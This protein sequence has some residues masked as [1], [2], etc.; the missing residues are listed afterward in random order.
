MYRLTR[1]LQLFAR[2]TVIGSLL[3]LPP[4]HTLANNPC[5]IR[6][7]ITANPA[8]SF[9]V[10]GRDVQGDGAVIITPKD[11]SEPFGKPDSTIFITTR[12]QSR[13]QVSSPAYCTFEQTH[14]YPYQA[15]GLIHSDAPFLAEFEHSRK[16]DEKNRHRQPDSEDSFL[17]LQPSFGKS[18]TFKMGGD[19]FAPDDDNQQH[20]RRPYGYFHEVSGDIDLTIM[21]DFQLSQ[22]LGEYLP[23][24]TPWPSLLNLLG[25]GNNLSHTFWLFAENQPEAIT[26][27]QVT[28]EELEDLADNLSGEL[29]LN[30]LLPK[31]HPDH[32]EKLIQQLLILQDAFSASSAALSE[33]VLE[34]IRERLIEILS[35]THATI[36]LEFEH[37]RL[38]RDLEEMTGEV[39]ANLV[40]AHRPDAGTVYDEDDINKLILQTPVGKQG[41]NKGK[42]ARASGKTS[43][44]ANGGSSVDKHQQNADNRDNEEVKSKPAAA[45]TTGGSPSLRI[46]FAG[47]QNVGKSSLAKAMVGWDCGF[48]VT[49]SVN[50]DL[51][52]TYRYER[53]EVKTLPGYG[54]PMGLMQDENITDFL[55]EHRVQSNDVIVLTTSNLGLNLYDM[56]A[57]RYFLSHDYRV[58]IVR[59][60]WNLE[61]ETRA[62]KR[63][64]ELDEDAKQEL[65]QEVEREYIGYIKQLPEW[66]ESTEIPPIVFT[67]APDSHLN[68]NIAELISAIEAIIHEKTSWRTFANSRV[69]FEDFKFKIDT[70]ISSLIEEGINTSE[71]FELSFAKIIKM[72]KEE[73][74]VSLPEYINDEFVNEAISEIYE[75]D[76]HKNLKK[77]LKHFNDIRAYHSDHNEFSKKLSELYAEK[78]KEVQAHLIERQILEAKCKEA[79][80]ETLKLKKELIAMAKKYNELAQKNEELA[81]YFKSR[82]RLRYLV[83]SP[84]TVAKR[85]PKGEVIRET[86]ERGRINTSSFFPSWLSR[87]GSSAVSAL[88]GAS[89]N[90]PGG[91]FRVSHIMLL[92]EDAD[93][94]SLILS[95][96]TRSYM[97]NKSFEFMKIKS[98]LIRYLAAQLIGSLQKEI[99]KKMNSPH[100]SFFQQPVALNSGIPQEY[101]PQELQTLSDEE[102]ADTAE[103]DDYQ[104]LGSQDSSSEY[105]YPNLIDSKYENPDEVTRLPQLKEW[106]DMVRQNIIAMGKREQGQSARGIAE[107]LT[108]VLNAELQKKHLQISDLE[109]ISQSVLKW[110]ESVE[111][112][113]VDDIIK[114]TQSYCDWISS[115]YTPEEAFSAQTKWLDGKL[116]SETPMAQELQSGLEKLRLSEANEG[117]L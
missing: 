93:S 6:V 12:I 70:I 110:L 14:K 53:F 24:H 28:S 71:L 61:L 19:L 32:R 64:K 72:M 108:T 111:Q 75:F 30:W 4:N 25:M 63:N 1:K 73:Y 86:T 60:K 26:S 49:L 99:D 5:S 91:A 109:H 96:H 17:L 50:P 57:L 104:S 115:G 78:E 107:S 74:G 18:H 84:E 43:S 38:R 21:G 31:L 9:V 77:M 39:S 65:R 46:V 85:V 34:L 10:C 11:D 59:N 42:Q 79:N 13:V 83:E 29:P 88:K 92:A 87:V 55:I 44:A 97:R 3:L 95:E 22:V 66:S 47:Q 8:Q 103:N 20:K 102:G 37:F 58:I 80:D 27:I 16:N 117:E 7:Q 94:R 2:I 82:Y 116:S 67:D 113:G 81:K 114:A 90:A 23:D 76:I 15:K 33:P 52:Q 40:L 56:Q 101:H 89:L 100:G 48:K 35:R 51:D 36:D 62:S 69:N 105:D 68:V 112:Y 98:E 45:T 41:G 54:S 106:Q